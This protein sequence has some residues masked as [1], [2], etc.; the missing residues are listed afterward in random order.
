[1]YSTI[2]SIAVY[3]LILYLLRVGF[4]S[5]LSN[6]KLNNKILATML[7]KLLFIIIPALLLTSCIETVA[8]S[9]ASI[10]YVNKKGAIKNP[11]KIPIKNAVLL[12]RVSNTLSRNNGDE[13]KFINLHVN[14]DQGRILLF[15]RVT[16]KKHLQEAKD[17]IWQ[18]KGV[19]ELMSEV[20]IS[21]KKHN[22]I[23]DS[24]LAS[25][26]KTK[27]IF[28][29]KLTTRNINVETYNNV[30]FLFGTVKKKPDVKTAS[31]TASKVTGVKKVVSYLRVKKPN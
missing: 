22:F 27:L 31:I 28:T 4:L 2:L 24:F 21:K 17:L 13:Y 23:A 25:K 11:L 7:K 9:T 8:V 1:M 14:V 15:G 19:K 20:E 3:K 30:V 29:K 16:E 6:L 18:V 12:G 26:V 5:I 10:I